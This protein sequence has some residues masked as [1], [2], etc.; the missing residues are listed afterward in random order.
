M[1]GCV[2]C[3]ILPLLLFIFHRFIQPIILKYLAPWT[4]KQAE[5]ETDNTDACNEENKKNG[6]AM[7]HAMAGGDEGRLKED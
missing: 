1:A 6:M 3:F 5:K 2:S 7:N 4:N